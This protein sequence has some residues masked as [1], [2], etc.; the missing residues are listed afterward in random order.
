MPE[1]TKYV[2]PDGDE[3]EPI[4][5][6]PPLRGKAVFLT[7]QDIELLDHLAEHLAAIGVPDT[8]RLHGIV[9][10]WRLA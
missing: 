6:P 4:E 2:M 5:I 1:L 8:E 7:V 10:A 9:A 3:Y